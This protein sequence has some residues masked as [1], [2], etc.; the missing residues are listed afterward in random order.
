MQ[1]NGNGI[2]GVYTQSRYITQLQ[3]GMHVTQ[4]A[5]GGWPWSLFY[6]VNPERERQIL[7]TNSCIWLLKRQ[8]WQSYT[9]GITKD[10]DANGGLL[11][12]A[13]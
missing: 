13:G 6:R 7:K 2:C 1:M 8:Y 12:W 4:L 11:D 9:Q 10:T 3:R 5:Q